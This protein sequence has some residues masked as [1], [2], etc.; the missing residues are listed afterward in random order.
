MF[1]Y[2]QEY[3][4]LVSPGVLAVFLMGLF[5]KK[6]TNKAAIVGIILSIFVAFFLKFPS[7]ELPFLDQMM[8]TLLIT[9]VIIVGVSLTTN[10]TDDDPKGIPLTAKTFR[11]DKIFNAA[12]YGVIII[13]VALYAIFW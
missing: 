12:S 11:T 5:W 2:I 1:Q 13:L 8:Y 3:T 4:G 6:T 9:I 7:L 10:E